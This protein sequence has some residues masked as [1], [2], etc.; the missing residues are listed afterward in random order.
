M[1]IDF[2]KQLKQGIKELQKNPIDI[3]DTLD[4]SASV[5][6]LRPVQLTILKKWYEERRDDKELIIKLPTGAGKTLIG[7][8]ILKSKLNS[9][10]GPCLYICPNNYLANQTKLEAER[11]GIE[12]CQFTQFNDIPREFLDGKAILITTAQKFFNGM[13][14]FGLDA[15]YIE[16]GTIVLDDSHACIDIVNN[17]FSITLNKG[18]G[19]YEELL[20]LFTPNL[21]QQG[22]GTFIDL[23]EGEF[24]SLMQIPYWSWEEKSSDVLRILS[25]YK[26]VKEIKFSWSILK[27]IIPKC[28]AFI[29][30]NSI[31]ISPSYIPIEKFPAFQNAKN[32][33]LMSATTQNDTFLIQGLGFRKETVSHPLVDPTLLWSGEKMLI[34]PEL[35]NADPAF[36]LELRSHFSKL[37]YPFGSVAIVPSNKK[38]EFY[39]VNGAELISQEDLIERVEYLKNNN[40]SKNRVNLVVI[41]NKYDGIDLPDSACRFLILDSLPYFQNL[42]DSYEERVRPSGD[43]I[44]KKRAQK[45]EQGLGRSVRGEK[46]FSVILL[47]G[48]HLVNFI[49]NSKTKKYFSPETQ[50]QIEIGDSIMSLSGVEQ[51]SSNAEFINH[52]ISVMKQCINRDESWKEYY[53]QSMNRPIEILEQEENYFEMIELEYD[54]E[55]EFY[56]G[57]YSLAISKI[58]DLA[59]RAPDPLEKGWYLQSKAR[60]ELNNNKMQSINTQKQAQKLNCN[61]LIPTDVI[62]YEKLEYVD[63]NRNQRIINFLKQ[64][65]RHEKLLQEV[66]TQLDY[67]SFG[68][69]ADKFE[70]ALDFIGQLLGYVTDRPDKKIRKGPDNL[71]CVR[72]NEYFM[73]ECKS[74]VKES[75]ESITKTEVGQF[76]NHCGWFEGVYGG[77]TKVN[78]FIFIPTQKVS[79]EGHFTHEVKVIRKHKLNFLKRNILNFI[80]E[81]A[82]Y[83]FSEM[84]IDK[85]NQLLVTHEL[86]TDDFEG[87]YSEEIIVTK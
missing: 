46:D 63:G 22:E 2:K 81:L 14:V 60:F 12:V 45:I 16:I 39:T 8:L 13:T 28:K 35:L 44:Q 30:G 62:D 54:A 50:K 1:A 15:R 43:L 20:D 32:K 87:L 56:K 29:S 66:Q 78:R 72:N 48:N 23:C 34:I 17:A 24:D 3:Y 38:S 49:T 25:K 74:E 80:K 79:Y 86:K 83:N 68:Q 69:R 53:T 7:L 5:G 85:I 27:D 65:S 26:D 11:F 36:S 70:T 31:E 57:N 33:I 55:R 52:I 75:R 59:D 18:E 58:Q 19:A 6:P 40:Y 21:K 51:F 82:A 42:S 37:E 77:M 76:N 64:Y 67:L 4:R 71:W 9:G 10:E 47:L 41:S 73:F 84:H 61:L